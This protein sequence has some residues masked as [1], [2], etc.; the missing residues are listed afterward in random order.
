MLSNAVKLTKRMWKSVRWKKKHRPD[1]WR[2]LQLS[3]NFK[4]NLC[5]VSRCGQNQRNQ[6]WKGLEG[7]QIRVGSLSRRWRIDS[8]K[9]L[10]QKT[11][12]KADSRKGFEYPERIL[13]LRAVKKTRIKNCLKCGHRVTLK[14]GFFLCEACRKSNSLLE[15]MGGVYQSYIA[16]AVR[17]FRL[18]QVR[19]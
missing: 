6:G 11:T 18:G 12:E 15:D 14:K 1:N 9:T 8:S 17:T 3:P 10:P 2:G 19:S 13:R 5:E 16:E 4:A 7:P